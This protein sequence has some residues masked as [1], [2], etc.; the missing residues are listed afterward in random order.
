MFDESADAPPDGIEALGGEGGL[1][2]AWRIVQAEG[3]EL[4]PGPERYALF[5]LAGRHPHALGGE[6]DEAPLGR[7]GGLLFQLAPVVPAPGGD[8]FG[9]VHHT[10]GPGRHGVEKGIHARVEQRGQPLH[11]GE[12]PVP[13]ELVE[14]ALDAPGEVRIIGRPLP[15]LRRPPPPLLFVEHH[16]ARGKNARLGVGVQGALGLGVKGAQGV[17]IIPPLIE[18]ERVLFLGGEKIHDAAPDGVLARGFH[19]RAPLVHQLLQGGQE[20]VPLE[21]RA[22]AQGEGALSQA[23]EGGESSGQGV[24]GGQNNAR[25]LAQKRIEGGHPLAHDLAGR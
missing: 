20:P 2:P 21:R 3:V 1:L 16:L 23:G 25:L 9:P 7:E 22:L 10:D 5:D 11:P 8:G 19:H 24:R 15:E 12:V 6:A 18:P 14:Q 4:E 17:D 13:F